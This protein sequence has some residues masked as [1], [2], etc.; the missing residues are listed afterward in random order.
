MTHL[1]AGTVTFLMT[2]I[3]GSTR[4]LQGLG[5]RY[6]AVL[7]H[8]HRLLREAFRAHG[9]TEIETAGDSLFYSFPSARAAVQAAVA[10]QHAIGGHAW[11][12]GWTVRVRM[13][14]HTGEP[15]VGELGFV[16]IDVHRTAR[17]GAAGH[18]GQILVSQ[19]TRDLAGD[20]LPNEISL[21]DLGE[22]RLKDLR[23]AER[24]YQVAAPGLERDFR[25]LRSL[26]AR[27]NNLPRQLTTF[28]GRRAEIADVKRILASG[29]LVTL[30]GPGGVGKTRL[31]LEVASDL[32]DL[33][34]EG[35]WLAEFGS[36]TDPEFVVPAVAGALGISEQPGR[37]LLATI[38]EHL[39][40]RRVL[41]IFDN[42]EHVLDAAAE[43]ANAVLRGC[44]GVRILATS[45][46]GLG[47]PGEAIFPIPS[48]SLPDEHQA[49]AGMDLDQFEAIRLFAERA[50]SASPAFRVTEANVGHVV[51]ICRRLDGVPLA[52]E[53]AAARVRAIAVDQ[54]A[55]RLDDRFRLLTGSSRLTVPRHQTLRQTI[56]W[57]YDLLADE[58][59]LLF[60]R[61]SV[62]AGSF[63][64]TAA[65]G[66]CGGGAVDPID[67]LDLLSRLVDKSLLLA[68]A[69]EGEVRFR[70]L[71][72][73]RQYA[74]DQLLASG[75][76]RDMGRR[77]RDWY[78]ALVE[79][80]A[81]AFFRGSESGA[82]LDQLDREHENLRAALQWSDD[83]PGESETG[84]R[85]AAALWRF[86]EI[87]GHLVEGRA[88][89]ERTLAAT[90]G[91]PEL[92]AEVLT[93]AGILALMQG[94]HTAAFGHHEQSLALRHQLGNRLAIA[95]A[96]SNLANTAALRGDYGRARSLYEEAVASFREAGDLYGT[97]Y[98]LVNMAEVVGRQGDEP[99]AR[100]IFEE[101][102]ATFRRVGDRW[103]EAYA[104][105]SYG[106]TASRWRDAP[107]ARTL[108]T[109]ALSIA[110]DL[111]DDRGVAR[112]LTHLADVASMQGETARAKALCLESLSIR[113]SL[114]D[115]PGVAGALEKL[116][117]VVMTQ[118]AE[119][120]ARLVGTAEALR[121]S[122][123]ARMPLAGQPDYEERL[124]AL[125]AMLDEVSYLAAVRAGRTMSPE[126]A[127]AT[128]P[129]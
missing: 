114:G 6:P 104:L 4:L 7:G 88:W 28:V 69:A 34:D 52:L 11:P 13:G 62:F 3:E 40:N 101:S 35:A 30:T 50:M 37:P 56:D 55:A 94:D 103:G 119:A 65:E 77:H 66:I 1:P 120:A 36:L 75:E 81:P 72:T 43:L 86:W 85:L 128:I 111:G 20:D 98:G 51:K 122:I 118:D 123:R 89:L 47:I 26:S 24:L 97:A 126:E 121:E 115:A 9:G 27:P 84:L 83:E 54:I 46:E 102:L 2:D 107:G 70:L 106:L 91:M 22:H 57:S 90:S 38:I 21:F 15:A 60:R 79:Q 108:L 74:R 78:L 68:D 87:R 58:E 117:W 100:W 61:L 32:L 95:S 96:A 48:L 17:I 29:P 41:L 23:E 5:D 44:A 109:Q 53:L 33:Y 71:E 129:P 8:H 76:A 127:V 93:G 113:R 92:R 64:L 19:T 82:P 49:R 73:V 116:A 124:H 25:P 18:G 42:C 110:H 45:R 99:A 112:V 67:M 39:R 12:A 59:R 16:G 105:D 14:L 125:Q 80:V 10:G 63:S 31:A